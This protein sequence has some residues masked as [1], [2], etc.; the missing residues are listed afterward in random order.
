MHTNTEFYDQL[1]AAVL[2]WQAAVKRCCDRQ[3]TSRPDLLT[4]E[5]ICAVTGLLA[6]YS[7]NTP[8]GMVATGA[9]SIEIVDGAAYKRYD[10]ITIEEHEAQRAAREAEGAAAEEQALID[11]AAADASAYTADLAALA[12][13]MASFAG[14]TPGMHYTEIEDLMAA[15]VATAEPAAVATLTA[16]S[17]RAMSVYSRL[18]SAGISGARLWRAM[19]AER[20]YV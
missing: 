2:G 1:N 3:P 20:K 15:K 13:A 11:Q 5:T 19:A 4:A 6:L 12:T 9:M 16:A 18:A 17:L 10:T 14:I 8:D 7:F